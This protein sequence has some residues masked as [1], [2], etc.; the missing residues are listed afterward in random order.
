MRLLFLLVCA[1]L[2]GC[3]AAEKGRRRP[4]TRYQAV[5]AAPMAKAPPDPWCDLEFATGNRSPPGTGRRPPPRGKSVG[6]LAPGRWVW[7]NLWATWCKPCLRE[8][9][10]LL[11][12]R[13]RLKQDG[14]AL[15][16]WFLSLDEDADELA[17]FL[18]AHPD[19]APPPSLRASNPADLRAWDQD[20]HFG[21]LHAHSHPHAG[22]ARRQDPLRSQRLSRR[23][24]LPEG[25]GA[26]ALTWRRAPRQRSR[27][28]RFGP[29]F[30]W[31]N[32]V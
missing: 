14:V 27:C 30:P 26:A 5:K 9:P 4:T 2:A 29:F 1:G 16:V 19:I 20:L 18:A 25:G 21:W 31:A 12:W 32:Y 22:R 3:P 15:D 7:F 24:R 11:G 28:A 13:D 6:T 8:M 10:V 17:K 23:R